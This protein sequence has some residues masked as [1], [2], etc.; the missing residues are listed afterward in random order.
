MALLFLSSYSDEYRWLFPGSTEGRQANR[1]YLLLN[2]HAGQFCKAK[3]KVMRQLRTEDRIGLKNKW[4]VTKTE[5]KLTI[6]VLFGVWCFNT[7]NVQFHSKVH[8][9]T[10]WRNNVFHN[11][12]KNNFPAMQSFLLAWLSH[13]KLLKVN[14]ALFVSWIPK[15]S[16]IAMQLS[17]YSIGQLACFAFCTFGTPWLFP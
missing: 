9:I 12:S 16:Q 1:P 3:C 5:Y 11:L 6:L 17:S 8:S 2:E 15:H 7:L 13:M 4:C 14:S 10:L